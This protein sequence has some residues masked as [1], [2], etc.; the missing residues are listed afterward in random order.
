M[1]RYAAAQISSLLARVYHVP[2]RVLIK[3]RIGVDMRE[4]D[5][6]AAIQQIQQP[7][8]IVAGTDDLEVPIDDSRRV[9]QANPRAEWLEIPGAGHNN[10]P[11]VNAELY[12]GT[13]IG[14][15]D[16]TLEFRPV[17]STKQPEKS[18]E[19]TN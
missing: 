14:F 13:I 3:A 17:Q 6:V 12:W 11:K 9:A 16:R 18:I 1:V 5:L 10:M 2:L 8:L 15:F 7:I 19:R 4:V